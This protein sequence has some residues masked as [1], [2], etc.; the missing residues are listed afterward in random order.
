M[1]TGSLTVAVLLALLVPFAPDLGWLIG[2]RAVQGVALA[3]IPASA[4]AYLSEEVHPKALVGAIGLFV[5]GNSVGGMSGRILTGWVADAWGWRVALAAVGAMALLCAVA[6]RLLLPKARN[7]TPAAVSP[8]ALARTLAGHLCRSA[9]VPAVRDRRAVHDGL[10]RGLHGHRLP[11]GGRA[12]RPLPEPDRLDLPD[13]PGRHGLLGGDRQAGRP[14][15]SARRAVRGGVHDGGRTAAV[16]AQLD[17]GGAGRSGADHRGLLRGPRGGVLGG[18]P[19][20]PRPGAPR[21]R[22]STRRRTTS[23]AAWAVRWAHSPSTRPDGAA[24][25]PWAW[26][27]SAA[28]RRSRCTRRARRRPNGA[29]RPRAANWSAHRPSPAP[30]A[31][32]A[33]L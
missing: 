15:R 5:A 14:A 32:P 2:L 29:R 20:R 24:R 31:C 4:T 7:F 25:S 18:E 16:P 3:G 12:L 6:F 30:G 27:R 19:Y 28:R 1:M 21:P 26:W 10:R 8:R 22:R 33:P 13:L 23:A 17:P 9:A 11:P